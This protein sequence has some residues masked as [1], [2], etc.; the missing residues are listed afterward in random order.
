MADIFEIMAPWIVGLVLIVML[1][2][3]NMNEINSL[4]S[5]ATEFTKSQVIKVIISGLILLFF[6]TIFLIKNVREGLSSIIKKV[7][8][9]LNKT[10]DEMLK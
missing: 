4:I 8:D 5:G 6:L 10:V 9:Y 2:A 7:M 3:V 1:T